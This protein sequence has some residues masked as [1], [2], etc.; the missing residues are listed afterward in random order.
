MRCLTGVAIAVVLAS[1]LPGCKSAGGPAP[2][3]PSAPL[4]EALQSWNGQR[5]F[6][7]GAGEA[8]SLALKANESLPKGDCDVAV[9]V[10]G[11][12]FDKGTLGLTLDTLGRAE[13]SGRMRGRECGEV[14]ASRRLTVSGLAATEAALAALERLLTT[15]EGHLRARDVA[16]D[17]APEARPPGP[18]ASEPTGSDGTSEER[19]LG[20][21]VGEWPKLL[22]AVHPLVSG[23][24]RHQG[25]IEF[26]ATV[27]IDG[28][29]HKPALVTDLAEAQAEQVLKVFGLWRYEPAKKGKDRVAA[30]VRGRTTLQIR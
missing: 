17:L 4:P 20:R 24:V 21:Q 18:V 7:A 22:L 8:R 12:S 13:V 2:Q 3:A 28:R 19:S 10:R 16:F 27:G 29:L 1:S 23:R 11:A 9:E 5:R 26:A 30:R 15:P 14:P 6:L 25:E